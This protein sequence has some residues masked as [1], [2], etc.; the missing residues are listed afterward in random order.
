[1]EPPPGHE[2]DKLGLA[3][4]ELRDLAKDSGGKFYR[5]EDLHNLVPMPKEVK[6]KL[7]PLI[8]SKEFDTRSLFVAELDKIFKDEPSC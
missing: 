6:D 8:S 3:E 4:K 7:A 1:M 2:K 5:E